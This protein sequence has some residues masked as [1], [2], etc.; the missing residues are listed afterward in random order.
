MKTLAYILILIN[1]FYVNLV[2]I[3]AETTIIGKNDAQA[4]AE[5][6]AKL[7]TNQPL[8]STLVTLP[9]AGGAVFGFLIGDELKSRPSTHDP[10]GMLLPGIFTKGVVCC[11]LAGWGIGFTG[12]LYGMYKL[13]GN[14]PSERLLGKS[15]EYIAVY[16][17]TYKRK[18]GI[19]R[20]KKAA[21]GSAIL[22]GLL[23]VWA[24]NSIQ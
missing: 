5:R 24:I 8:S 13:G 11:C 18:I 3:F 21:V 12:A 17:A 23:L 1:L 7:D 14:V 10:E 9:A 22:Q 16:T 6:D 19:E 20:A 15:P 4:D 2:P